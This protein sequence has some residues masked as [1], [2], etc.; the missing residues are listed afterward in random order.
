MDNTSEEH[1]V[2]NDKIGHYFC[3]L[4]MT[5]LTDQEFLDEWGRVLNNTEQPMKRRFMALMQLRSA[6][7]NRS[8]NW[9]VK[10]FGDESALLKH[11]L[12]FC[13]GQMRA[14]VAIPTLFS[15]LEKKEEDPMVRH[16]A[17]EALGAIG[18]SSVIADLQKF[19]FDPVREVRETVELALER[20]RFFKETP[21][22]AVDGNDIH[23]NSIDPAPP[24][25]SKNV[26]ELENILMN[27]SEK[28]FKR[29]RAMFA[30][31]NLSTDEAI[32][33]LARALECDGALFKHEIAYVLGQIQSPLAVEELNKSLKN[34]SEQPMVR[35]E[36]AE[37]L[38]S[39]GTKEC[40]A[41]L[42][43]HIQDEERVVRESVEVAM[44][45]VDYNQNGEPIFEFNHS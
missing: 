20:L 16:E 7:C 12:A 6:P 18:D 24:L 26:S 2:Q 19:A 11:E 45:I 39:I 34:L 13:L 1:V 5:N 33:V 44:S 42:T 3:D 10:A 37:A 27:P 28:L 22:A 30:L 14:T 35:H 21:N 29:Y 40:E 23:Y 36:A 31:R 43:E 17:A 32:K 25:E 4:N 38:G 8:A 41:I 15:V 9:I